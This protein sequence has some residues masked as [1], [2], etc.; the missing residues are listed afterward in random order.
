MRI[1][2][3][4]MSNK[5]EMK[6]KTAIQRFLYCS[7][8]KKMSKNGNYGN[9]IANNSFEMEW[10][11]LLAVKEFTQDLGDVA[12]LEVFIGDFYEYFQGISSSISYLSH[13]HYVIRTL[14]SLAFS[15]YGI[16]DFRKLLL[17]PEYL[18]K[19]LNTMAQTKSFKD[20]RRPILKH[21][22]NFHLGLLNLHPLSP[23]K[24]TALNLIIRYGKSTN[25]KRKKVYEN[26]PMINVLLDYLTE[27]EKK[28]HKRAR[29]QLRVFLKWLVSKGY[30]DC[31]LE[32]DVS[33][34]SY[35]ML[36]EYKEYLNT[37]R[38]NHNLTRESAQLRIQVIKRW[39]SILKSKGK[40][41]INPASKLSNFNL[42]RKRKMIILTLDEMKRFFECILED[43]DA[44]IWYVLFGLQSILGLRASELLGIT[45]EAVNVKTGEVTVYRKYNKEQVLPLRGLPLL[46]LKSYFE[47]YP[48]FPSDPLWVNAQGNRLTYQ[49]LTR[50]FHYFKKRANIK[51]IEGATHNFRHLI[52][53]EL[54]FQEQDLRKLK[55]LAGVESVRTLNIYI[56]CRPADV[57]V[58]YQEKYKPIG[59]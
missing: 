5:V 19:V 2:R 33:N 6:K 31:L 36:L 7:P 13:T 18:L 8:A 48:G 9:A 1:K 22:M 37:R 29:I 10:Q 34:I 57:Y 38:K 32:I 21:V 17:S 41:T 24:Y 50:K 40:I 49:E 58:E 14:Q 11:E 15:D 47:L 54:F 25:K 52:M 56:H 26:H 28:W 20:K 39:F 42:K 44:F 55:V 46:L 51:D 30:F 23:E 16:A 4:Y 53:S 43:K 35:E 45:R 3:K 12:S 27:K 59:V